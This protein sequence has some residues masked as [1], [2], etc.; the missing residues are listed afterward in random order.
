MSDSRDDRRAPPPPSINKTAVVAGGSAY[1]LLVADY[2]TEMLT[3][4]HWLV[5]SKELMVMTLALIAP[6]IHL[7]CRIFMRRLARLERENDPCSN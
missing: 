3:A 4:G 5:P 7:L 6:V 1:T 2:I